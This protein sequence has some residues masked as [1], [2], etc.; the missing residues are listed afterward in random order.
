ME[1]LSVPLLSS[2]ID[3]SHNGSVDQPC[4]VR[5]HTAYAPM[6][7]RAIRGGIPRRFQSSVTSLRV[8]T[9]PSTTR[10]EKYT[11][12]AT[13]WPAASFPSQWKTRA[14]ALNLP[15]KRTAMIRPATSWIT[16]PQPG[17]LVQR[18]GIRLT[19][20]QHFRQRPARDTGELRR[21]AG[22]DGVVGGH[23]AE[24]IAPRGSD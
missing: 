24:R 10:R 23:V 17:R 1:F 9:L 19:Q 20:P 12:L 21:E 6:T 22:D 16:K 5:S 7:L 14:P 18:I 15:S 4:L 8:R 13:G 2:P 3:E 11:P